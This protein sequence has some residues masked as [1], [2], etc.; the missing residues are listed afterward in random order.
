M[1]ECRKLLGVFPRSDVLPRPKTRTEEGDFLYEHDAWA[2]AL[3]LSLPQNAE[4]TDASAEGIDL[5]RGSA[6]ATSAG[7]EGI[8]LA[9]GSA[10]AKSAGAEGSDL[11][12]GPA[13]AKS[14]GAEGRD[15]ARGSAAAK[16]AGNES[17]D[18]ARGSAAAKSA[19]ATGFQLANSGKK[20]GPDQQVLSDTDFLAELDLKPSMTSLHTVAAVY[21]RRHLRCRPLVADA[22]RGQRGKVRAWL[23]VLCEITSVCRWDC[24]RMRSLYVYASCC[25]R[26]GGGDCFFLATACVLQIA[27]RDGETFGTRWADIISSRLRWDVASRRDLAAVLRRIVAEEVRDWPAAKLLQCLVNCLHREASGMW[28]DHWSAATYLE[29]SPFRFL[30][31]C[32]DLVQVDVTNS[33]V[34]VHYKR[35]DE[36]DVTSEYVLDGVLFLLNLQELIAGHLECMGDMHWGEHLDVAILE[37]KLNVGFCLF[38]DRAYG[39]GGN[40]LYRYGRTVAQPDIWIM[41][42]YIQDQHFQVVFLK[43]NGPPRCYYTDAELPDALREGPLLQ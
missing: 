9:R 31:E 43:S 39:A 1:E 34:A 12:R 24:C 4:G 42:H 14:A 17:S 10:A 2:E 36:T 3:R 7:A 19:G 35:L 37:D 32:N 22:G 28:F 20:R 5:A 21:C 33:G 40:V 23:Q 13:A 8:D 16:S 29:R 38:G 25:V 27:M 6:A 18:L 26:G 41:L 30:L 11:A 15:Q